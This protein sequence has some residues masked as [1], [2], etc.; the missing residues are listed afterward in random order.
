VFVIGYKFYEV[1]LIF[2]VSLVVNH[3]SMRVKNLFDNFMKV[4]SLGSEKMILSSSEKRT[5]FSIA[6]IVGGRLLMC[7]R[8]RR[9]LFQVLEE[10][11]L[12]F[13]PN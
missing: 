7:M 11:M 1:L 5:L 6:F 13:I 9:V 12:Y 8:K 4:F 2:K 10:T 3:L